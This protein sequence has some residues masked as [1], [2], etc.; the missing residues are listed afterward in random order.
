[1]VDR[2]L[3]SPLSDLEDRRRGFRQGLRS[4]GE[5]G[6]ERAAARSI[7]PTRPPPATLHDPPPAPSRLSRNWPL[8]ALPPA[9]TGPAE[10]DNRVLACLLI[11]LARFTGQWEI[12]VGRS[13]PEGHLEMLCAALDRRAGLDAAVRALRP[14]GP[15]PGTDSGQLPPVVVRT[16]AP[17]DDRPANRTVFLDVGPDEVTAT[18]WSDAYEPGT[19]GGLLRAADA[20]LRAGL[21]DGTAPVGD[22]PLLD[23]D[24]VRDLVGRGGP[25]RELPAAT[26]LEAF[27]R[28]AGRY[29]D[30]IAVADRHGELTYRELDAAA[31]ALAGR[32]AAER[33][34]PE[35][36]VAILVAR[37]DKRWAMACLGVLKA[38]AAWIPVDPATPATRLRTMLE[39]AG[40][41]AVVTDATYAGR[42]PHGPWAVVNLDEPAAGEPRPVLVPATSPRHSAY[43]I[44]TSGSSGT[45]RPVVIEQHSLVNLVASLLRLFEVGPQD[46]I[47]QYASPGFDVSVFEIFTAFLAG[48]TLRMI[49]EDDRMSAEGLSRVLADER[50]T[51]AELPPALLELMDPGRF[52]DLRV[53]SVGG[54]P[55][56]GELATRWSRGH[57]FVNGYGTTETTIGVIYQECVG[58][59]ATPP[60]I[61]RPVD[62]H[63][64]YVLDERLRP[65]PVGA[66]G[67]LCVGGASVAR[68]YPGQP[69]VTADKF[70]PDP[71]SGHGRLYRTGDLVRWN[72]DGA[73]VFLGRRDRQVKVRGQRVELGEIEAALSLDPEVRA[74]VVAAAADEDGG[75]RLVAYYVPAGPPGPGTVR[76]RLAERLPAALV[77]GRV[78]P[79]PNIP[80]TAN[81]KVDF[82]GLARLAEPAEPETAV[83]DGRGADEPIEGGIRQEMAA[84]L[85]GGPTRAEDFFAAGGDS[86]GAMRLMARI[87]AR[88]GV[89]VP[90]HAFFRAPTPAAL[91]TAVRA[92]L[93]G[94]DPSEPDHGIPAAPGDRGE[95]SSAQQRL[96]LVEQLTPDNPGY[97]VVEAFRLTGPLDCVAL[98]RAVDQV[99]QRHEILRTRYVDHDG[100]P[101]Q[102]IG[103]GP[104]PRLTVTDPLGE[105]DLPDVVA[106]QVAAPFDLA[107]G[108]LL[109]VTLIPTGPQ[110]H[111]LLIVAHHIVSD[112]RSTELVF[113]EISELYGGLVRGEPTPLPAP[114]VRYL[115]FARWE[116][117]RLRTGV[118]DET[119]RYWQ[120]H[121][122]GAPAELALPFDRPRPTEPTHR[123]DVVELDVPA[124]LAEAISATGTVHGVT[125]F[126]VALTAFVA[127]LARYS[128]RPD[129]VVGAPFA[130]RLRPELDEVIGFF[131]NLL[132]LRLDC[133]DD[134]TLGEL[135]Q[136]VRETALAVQQHQDL[137][138]DRLV[139]LTVAGGRDP[140]RNPLMQVSLQFYDA[141]DARLRLA[142]VTSEKFPVADPGSPFDLSVDVRR[143]ARNRLN[144]KINYSMDLFDRETVERFAGHYLRALTAVTATPSA[145]SHAWT[146]L[147]GTEADQLTA[148]TRSTP[149]PST[150]LVDLIERQGTRDL[151][152]P[153]LVHDGGE[154]GYRDFLAQAH[155]V[156]HWL[157]GMGVRRGDV[158]GTMLPRGPELI[159]VLTAALLAGAA[160]LPL[161]PEYPAARLE[162]M[163]HDARAR[164][165]VTRSDLASRFPPGVPG[166][167]LD[168][169]AGTIA[170]QPTTAPEVD[171]HPDDAAFLTFTSGSTG[172][173]KGT[174]ITH[175][176][177][178]RLVACGPDFHLGEH[179]TVLA[180]ATASFDLST[181][182]MWTSLAKGYTVAVYP[183]GRPDLAHL[184]RFL[185]RHRVS[186]A[187]LTTAFANLLIDT[188]PATL[189]WVRRLLIGGE[190]M[191]ASHIRRLQR[192][193]PDLEVFNGYGPAEVAT[194]TTA[195]PVPV[196]L[197]PEAV[198]VSIGR[199]VCD[200]TLYVLDPHG[201]RVP[202]NIAGE[203]YIGGA[204]LARGYLSRPADTADRFV[205]D[206]F[207]PPGRRLYRTG[208][209]VRWRPDGL[210]DFIGRVD[211]QVKLRGFRIEPGEIVTV[212]QGHPGVASAFV[213]PQGAGLTTELV[214]YVV[215][216]NPDVTQDI[217]HHFLKQQLPEHLV[218]GAV[219][220]LDA[221]PL[222]SRGKVDR[223]ALPLP[224]RERRAGQAWE[225]PVGEL[226]RRIAAIWADVLQLENVGRFEDFFR[227]GGNSLRAMQVVARMRAQLHREVAPQ[228]VFRHPTVADLGFALADEAEGGPTDSPV[229]RGEPSAPLSW[230]QRRL[231]A[232]AQLHPMRPDYTISYALRLRGALDAAALSRALERVVERHEILR[233]RFAA[234]ADGEVRQF[235]EPADAFALIESDLSR[236]PAA[237]REQRAAQLARQEAREPFDLG[238]AP[239]IRALLN[240]LDE[241]DHQLVLV[242]HHAAFDGWSVG[243]L[244]D[245]IAAGYTAELDATTMDLPP[246][247]LQYGD[248]AEWEQRRASTTRDAEHLAYWQKKLADLPELALPLDHQRPATPTGA[249]GRFDGTLLDEEATA[250]LRTRAAE[251]GTTTLV[252]LLTGF[253]ST[254]ARLADQTDIAV[255][256]AVSGR[257]RPELERL[258]GFFVNTLV[259]RTDLSDDPT[260]DEAVARV[261]ETATSAYA[262]Q[263]VSFDRLVDALR[264]NRDPNRT[265]LIDVI[266]SVASADDLA[267]RLRDVEAELTDVPTGSAKFDLDVGLVQGTR[268][269]GSLEY[270]AEL[271]QQRTVERLWQE[272]AGVLTAGLADGSVALSKLGRPEAAAD[273]LPAGAGDERLTAIRDRVRTLWT[274][275]LNLTEVD[276]DEDFF[277]LGGNSL[278]AILVIS[279][280]REQLNLELPIAMVFEESSV[281]ALARAIYELSPR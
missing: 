106:R 170:G 138:F 179:E 42:I 236:L 250:L 75:R 131:V 47:L 188:D 237:H 193:L 254:L 110:R 271:F 129:I 265:P 123:G 89:E 148:Y 53:A 122:A 44:F 91:A 116:Q 117:E 184:G 177:F 29:G 135:L 222:T 22:V 255:G 40:P 231:W 125:P 34:N 166:V 114:A 88:F 9:T 263:D 58:R 245:E 21:A 174:V 51:V 1:M 76:Q 208:D 186:V 218:P 133:T 127:V 100:E 31:A 73:I 28:V 143:Y 247:R 84:I 121:L 213:T 219:V 78:V 152:T 151:R 226:E 56:S 57:R 43:L 172:R 164:L 5:R 266:F 141:A 134:P 26:V 6:G 54:E 204:G 41:M 197:A 38:G 232:H 25:V 80:V 142:D 196:P 46:R 276:E 4:S 13:G 79:V 104:V 68:G 209:L 71:F 200:T 246:M 86:I 139:D 115:A 96:W 102:I 182:E 10:P 126:M 108:P 203:L 27:D 111:L 109:R 257:S 175:R 118:P 93:D 228:V 181:F 199:P 37:D 66:V 144:L 24:E 165:V 87:R 216:N 157:R 272:Y 261:R 59:W 264:P 77:P 227:I 230:A 146:M 240:R 277:V 169:Q 167:T 207:G 239:L 137:P 36:Y 258:I 275:T 252:L 90:F 149:A 217:V 159:V 128:G 65:V 168:D 7:E 187:F 69:G 192:T 39:L 20:T 233:S 74:A 256:T 14:A 183:A 11:A 81:G 124:E 132:P 99:V 45:P 158:V 235:V 49:G 194:F 48:A 189:G 270:S 195:Y 101:R 35:D 105:H 202:V 267:L 185:A 190:A 171:L 113:D 33:G 223:R 234:G 279:Q 17:P 243:L 85:G 2:G 162:L 30:R 97:K 205:P 103:G 95:L 274:S 224:H 281:N 147:S 201:N 173:P 221:L 241:D 72:D 136:R 62:N 154:I 70:V 280:L 98:G 8:P 153:A 229:P 220:L 61:G 145:R 55:F 150:T 16:G 94:A 242:V 161:D 112:G 50:I 156:A 67:E 160:Y 178:I 176:G 269:T 238:T 262:H 249:A 248:Y 23:D 12:A 260:F 119:I 206:P 273:D 140:D 107:D 83:D 82:A 155:R 92:Q 251:L 253:V 191:S 52:P 63:R 268:I 32:L 3:T 211:D 15:A 18:W 198:T 212:L 225:E 215:P 259:L 278:T 244:M 120:G 210:L 180:M 163:A 64:A 130:G 60:P 19:I 214:A